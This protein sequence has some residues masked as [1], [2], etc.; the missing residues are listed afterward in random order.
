[1]RRPMR[2]TM[3]SMTRRRCAVAGK[4]GACHFQAAAAF[5][6]DPIGPVDHDFRDKGVIKEPLRG[7]KAQD[8]IDDLP[9]EPAPFLGCQRDVRVVD[10]VAEG[11][12]DHAP[13]IT[14]VE[15]AVRDAAA[16]ADSQFFRGT[17]RL[18]P[19]SASGDALRGT[20]LRGRWDSRVAAGAELAG[21]SGRWE[22]WGASVAR[23][24]RAGGC[25]G[26]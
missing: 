14:F 7:A 26:S 2:E 13:D 12:P 24:R 6:V 10:E 3:R 1:M 11:I 17:A 4:G 5:H 20:W 15:A 22:P 16:Q 21:D 25:S 19:A 8:L 18:M 9:D 23:R